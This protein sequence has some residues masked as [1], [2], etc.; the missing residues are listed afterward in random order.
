M[1]PLCLPDGV[2]VLCHYCVY[3]F[4][5]LVISQC[6]DE[7]VVYMPVSELIPKDLGDRSRAQTGGLL[8]Y[9]S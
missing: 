9:L 7:D 4:P 6:L 3:H 8:Q 5:F 2:Y 1:T